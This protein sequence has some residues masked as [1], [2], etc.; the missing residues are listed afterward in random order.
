MTFSCYVGVPRTKI[1]LSEPISDE[2]KDHRP[3]IS[4]ILEISGLSLVDDFVLDY[5][6]LVLLGVMRRLLHWWTAGPLQFRL[7]PRLRE[8]ISQG[9]LNFRPFVP[10]N[11]SRKPRA[12]TDLSYWKASE[13]RSFF[14]LFWTSS[15]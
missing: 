4:P 14:V 12:L 7:P 9:L 8:K 13:L 11:F 5:L 1:S 2:D 10:S 6:H 15:T 3:H